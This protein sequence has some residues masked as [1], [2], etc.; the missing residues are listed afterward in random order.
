MLK[1]PNEAVHTTHHNLKKGTH[2]EQ[3]TQYDLVMF[4]LGDTVLRIGRVSVPIRGFVYISY[5]GKAK[6]SAEQVPADLEQI[7]SGGGCKA[8]T[9]KVEIRENGRD[10][11]LIGSEDLAAM[12]VKPRLPSPSRYCRIPP[13][14]L[15]YVTVLISISGLISTLRGTTF[16]V[17]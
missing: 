15:K 12:R 9:T 6:H 1:G 13:M 17:G 14:S 10:G 7:G 3:D 11:Y 2:Q 16:L 5:S 8:T 4:E